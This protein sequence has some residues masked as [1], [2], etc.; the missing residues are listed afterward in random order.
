LALQTLEQGVVKNMIAFPEGLQEKTARDPISFSADYLDRLR[1]GDDETLQHFN[2]YFRRLLRLKFWGRFNREQ[3]EEL[4][5]RVIAA[6]TGKI[7]QG[8]P[9][10]ASRLPAY[11]FRISVALANSKTPA[12]PK[13]GQRHGRPTRQQLRTFFSERK[14]TVASR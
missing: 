14:S 8:E 5:N 6:A 12:S 7:D 3:G 10:D 4:A 1:S 9:G 11:V 2:D 13:S